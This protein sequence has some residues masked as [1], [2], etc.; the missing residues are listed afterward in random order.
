MKND[1]NWTN[2]SHQVENKIKLKAGRFIT[3]DDK[4]EIE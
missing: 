4:L 1:E 3:N 2:I